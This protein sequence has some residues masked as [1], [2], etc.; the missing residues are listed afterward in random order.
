MTHHET[1]NK[2]S[3]VQAT[4]NEAKSRHGII[5]STI[6]AAFEAY[7]AALCGYVATDP[8]ADTAIDHLETRPPPTSVAPGKALSL[9]Q[10][11]DTRGHRCARV[12]LVDGRSGSAIM[13]S[14]PRALVLG[15]RGETGG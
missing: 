15:R 8:A 1:A 6:L 3:P 12:Q 9:A 7:G 2:V 11:R 14:A 4:Q 10:P 5:L 13:R